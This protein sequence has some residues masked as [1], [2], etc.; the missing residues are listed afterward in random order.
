MKKI[1]LVV[2]VCLY[3]YLAYFVAV[4]F[5][6]TENRSSDLV[7]FEKNP[8]KDYLELNMSFNNELKQWIALQTKPLSSN[9]RKYDT[10][11]VW[12][13]KTKVISDIES[14][15]Y[16]FVGIVFSNN[17][18]FEEISLNKSSF[19]RL[20][21]AIGSISNSKDERLNKL[22]EKSPLTLVFQKN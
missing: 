13:E 16:D 2:R 7:G 17:I 18:E 11:T 4:E 6:F 1:I 10:K 5:I 20:S 19:Y 9:I 22:T 21:E 12:D 15:G 8:N 14:L 3:L